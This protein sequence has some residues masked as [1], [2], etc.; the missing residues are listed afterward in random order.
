MERGARVLVL[1]L[2]RGERGHTE[3][4]GL[5][6]LNSDQLAMAQ[7]RSNELKQALDALGGPQHSFLGVR[8]YLDSGV[9]RTAAGNLRVERPI[10]NRSLVASGTKVV[11]DE[12]LKALRDFRP[13]AVVTYGADGLTGH[14]DHKLT[15]A[16]TVAAVRSYRTRGVRPDLW[17]LS[18]L[19]RAQVKVGSSRTVSAKREAIA[20]HRSQVADAGSQFRIGELVVDPN[21]QEGLRILRP[22]PLGK[23]R[24]VV[25]AVWALPLGIIAA[26]AGTLVHQARS[27]GEISLPYGIALALV[28][29]YLL[30]ML[31]ILDL[32]FEHDYQPVMLT[33]HHPII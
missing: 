9:R 16:A 6:F 21:H 32:T 22:R 29:V 19:S 17:Q 7:H 3:L 11:A 8:S 10:D 18:P 1:T 12:I 33:N 26:I 27:F 25:R 23:L 24:D 31:V 14:P 28:L 20:A 30:L 4:P 5:R 13:D 15:H 2:T